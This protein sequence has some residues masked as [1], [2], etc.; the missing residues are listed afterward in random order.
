MSNPKP[1]AAELGDDSLL[2][3][4]LKAYANEDWDRHAAPWPAPATTFL[5]DA[6]AAEADALA[7]EIAA[8]AALPLDDAGWRALLERAHVD[9]SAFAP[10][11]DLARWAEDLRRRAA[12][13]Q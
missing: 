12:A 6:S 3:Q 8:L 10:A 1:P 13:D 7:D 5:A 4:L 9:W 2:W 11:G